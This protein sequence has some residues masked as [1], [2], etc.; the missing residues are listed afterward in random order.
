MIFLKASHSVKVYVTR[1]VNRTD[2]EEGWLEELYDGVYHVDM[3]QWNMPVDPL[4]ATAQ[5]GEMADY[6]CGSEV[7]P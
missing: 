5:L 1:L 4:E 2:S 3:E 7:S 6:A